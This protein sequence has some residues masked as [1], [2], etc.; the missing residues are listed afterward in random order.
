MLSVMLTLEMLYWQEIENS[1][2]L[3]LFIFRA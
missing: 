1:L 3:R 2:Y